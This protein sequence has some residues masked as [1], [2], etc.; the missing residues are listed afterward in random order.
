M[1][2]SCHKTVARAV[3]H[4]SI[5][6]IIVQC[7]KCQSFNEFPPEPKSAFTKRILLSPGS[8]FFS[9]PVHLDYGKVVEGARFPKREMKRSDIDSLLGNR[10]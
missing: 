1:C 9:S 6:S 4:D 5:R 3:W 2:G 7:F 10:E 8:F